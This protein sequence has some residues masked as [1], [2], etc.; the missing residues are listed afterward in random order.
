MDA[1]ER[2]ESLDMAEYREWEGEAEIVALF[3]EAA[4]GGL[5]VYRDALR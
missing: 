3:F 4:D 1:R 5:V 2:F